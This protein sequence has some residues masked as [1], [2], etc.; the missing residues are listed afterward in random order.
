M[1]IGPAAESVPD[2]SLKNMSSRR[3]S[4]LPCRDEGIS[5]DDRMIRTVCCRIRIKRIS[6]WYAMAILESINDLT[7]MISFCREGV[8][9]WWLD[10][11][12][13]EKAD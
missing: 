7:M 1:S 9:S 13:L 4:I 11:I 5:F 12:K 8:N 3:K 6:C 2:F 10:D